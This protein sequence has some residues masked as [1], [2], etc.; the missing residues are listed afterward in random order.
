MQ[1]TRQFLSQFLY[2]LC[3]KKVGTLY[4]NLQWLGCSGNGRA[5]SSIPV[6]ME[7]RKYKITHHILILKVACNID[8]KIKTWIAK[9]WIYAIPSHKKSFR[10]LDPLISDQIQYK[11]TLLW[12]FENLRN[13]CGDIFMIKGPQTDK[14]PSLFYDMDILA[15][16]TKKIRFRFL[17]QGRRIYPWIQSSSR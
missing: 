4:H 10:N 17:W 6:F 12:D 3:F 15:S 1:D 11:T 2:F 8:F 5:Q 9:E 13:Q 14:W 7:R 16:N